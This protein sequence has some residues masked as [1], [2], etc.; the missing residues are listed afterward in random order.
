MRLRLTLIAVLFSASCVVAA[1]GPS[2]ASPGGSTASLSDPAPPT[3]SLTTPAAPGI[4]AVE[5]KAAV[6]KVLADYNSKSPQAVCADMSP[7]VIAWMN[8]FIESVYKT[9]ASCEQFVSLA[10]HASEDDEGN[11]TAPEFRRISVVRWLQLGTDGQYGKALTLV[12]VSYPPGTK[13]LAYAHLVAFSFQRVGGKLLLAADP[14]VANAVQGRDPETF[15]NL[16]PVDAD[17]AGTAAS[18]PAPQFPCQGTAQSAPDPAGDV[19]SGTDPDNESRTTAPWLD[20]QRVVAHGFGT[21]HPCLEIDF[22][23]PVRP[24]TEITLEPD[25][26]T[27]P[28]GL[29]I[30]ADGDYVDDFADVGPTPPFGERGSAIFITFNPHFWPWK[31]DQ[32]LICAK[33]MRA[34]DPTYYGLSTASDGW[35]LHPRASDGANGECTY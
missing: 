15:Q 7:Q 2:A 13:G 26:V 22:A 32:L 19:E 30:G 4:P 6:E 25:G 9:A 23:A 29:S 16:A 5:L 31:F 28:F 33:S 18:L 35:E 3:S 8:T 34:W 20:I 17:S 1:C 10:F 27:P 11:V 12:K 14:P 21:A 24:L